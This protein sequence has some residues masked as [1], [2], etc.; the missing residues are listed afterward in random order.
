M[1]YT[2]LPVRVRPFVH[3]DEALHEASVGKFYDTV[4]DTYEEAHRDRLCD[5]ILEYFINRFLPE[6]PRRILDLGGGV[7]RFA[8]PLARRGYEVVLYDVSD[9][10]LME[11][12]SYA[13]REHVTLTCMRGSATDLRS[14]PADSFEGVI[15]MNSVLDYCADHQRA[16]AEVRRVLRPRATFIGSVNNRFAYAT[17]AELRC[18]KLS[19]FLRSMQTGDRTI[20]WGP[21]SEWHNTHDFTANEIEHALRAASF[22]AVQVLGVFNL[23]GKYFSDADFMK[24]VEIEAFCQIQLDFAQRPEYLNNSTDYLFVCEK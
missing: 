12:A 22:Q 16:I 14:F 23:L 24:T 18:G 5:Q 7:G 20:S 15:C 17:A 4:S 9:G 6:P 19:L 21:S 11:A 13:K 10:M 8:I 3:Q 1:T 2:P